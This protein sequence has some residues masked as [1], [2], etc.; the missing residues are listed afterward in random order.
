MP[1]MRGKSKEAF[2][3]NVKTEIDA[4]KPQDQSLAIAYSLKRRSKKAEGG[5][6][7]QEGCTCS[8]CSGGMMAKGGTAAKTGYD[9]SDPSLESETP[10]VQY[11][12][13][14]PQYKDRQIVHPLSYQN[15][16]AQESNDTEA[17]ANNYAKGGEAM[18]PKQPMKTKRERAMEAFYAQGGPVMT[19]S[20]YQSTK[21]VDTK[22]DLAYHEED[23]LSQSH[24]ST[25][26][27]SDPAARAEDD[28][29]LG[30]HGDIEEGP[31]GTWMADGGQIT[32][33]YADT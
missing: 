33:N 23:N 17:K 13:G 25:T 27:K 19:D 30:Q 18:N 12:A 14:T 29:R 10:D 22:P 3:K 31:Q 15:A 21:K 5:Q 6:M 4:G 28:R 8:K 7:H 2:E 11:V 16:K 9:H 20:G 1:L 26:P 24:Q 32:D